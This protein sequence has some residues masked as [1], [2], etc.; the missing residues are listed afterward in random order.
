MDRGDVEIERDRPVGFA[1]VEHAAVM[2]EAGA[3]DEDVGRPERSHRLLRERIDCGVRAY[4][5][6]VAPGRGK[7]FELARV[8]IGRDHRRALG[9]EG[10]AD[11]AADPLSRGGDDRDLAVQS[12]GHCL[13]RTN[14]W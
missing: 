14:R 1:A 3:I 5:E 11:G 12:T 6:L 4:V 13:T 9:D 2:H 7:A 10:L 8:E